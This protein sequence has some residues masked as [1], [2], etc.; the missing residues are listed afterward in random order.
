MALAIL[1]SV[2]IFSP[3]SPRLPNPPLKDLAANH[4]VQLGNYASLKR[5][6]DKPYADILTSQYE[7]LTIDG[8]PNWMFNDGT[9]RPSPTK[10]DYTNI[11]Q[12]FNF[13]RAHNMPVQIHHLV[14]GED[15]W[16]PNWL[17]EGNY[18]KEQLLNILH[19]HIS[20][21]AG[22]YS[23]QVREWT[24][25]NEAFTRGAQV[26]GLHDWWLD[27]TGD[28]SYID[29]SFIWA[30]QADPNAKLILNDFSNEGINNISNDMYNYVKD[31]KSRGVPIDGIGM[32]M[33]IDAG[34]S[35]NKDDVIK[36][37]QRFDAIGVKTYITE[38]DVNLNQVKDD[39]K[40]RNDL[41]SSIYYQMARACIESKSCPSFA[42]LGITDKETWYNE[43]GWT[44]SQPLLFDDKYHVKPAFYAFRQAWQQ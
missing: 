13:A 5:L 8:E 3:H 28:R 42:E 16:L 12:V 39:A 1:L 23:G 14:W 31:A 24:V 26:N 19:D 11:D 27:H 44:K 18:N 4:Q 34:H 29:N 10:Y 40:Y 2:R 25:V 21:V 32:Q 17:K 33:H 7:F 6:S 43:L 36:N 22:H 41:Q 35:P 15:K 20:N 9:L 37:M 38:F 30:H